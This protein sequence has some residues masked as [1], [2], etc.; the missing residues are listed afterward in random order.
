MKGLLLHECTVRKE[1]LLG[2]SK[3]SHL[4]FAAGVSGQ[5]VK[6]KLWDSG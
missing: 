1:G 2:A 4:G 5:K 3:I 6:V